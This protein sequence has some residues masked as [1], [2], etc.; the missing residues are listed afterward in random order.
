[1]IEIRFAS[2]DDLPRLLPLMAFLEEIDKESGSVIIDLYTGLRHAKNGT[3]EFYK[4]LGY[5][6]QGLMAKLYL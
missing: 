4:K 3:R 5:G 2:H 1:M 6:N